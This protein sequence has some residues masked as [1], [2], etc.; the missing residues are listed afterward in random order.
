MIW[1]SAES[2]RVNKKCL[3]IKGNQEA[4]TR[5]PCRGSSRIPDVPS[6]VSFNHGH[7]RLAHFNL[8]AR[9][10]VNVVGRFRRR[11]DL[12]GSSVVRLVLLGFIG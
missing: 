6:R 7:Q 12:T 3:I 8:D 5:S 4:S 1:H 9:A 11:N 10:I 2:A